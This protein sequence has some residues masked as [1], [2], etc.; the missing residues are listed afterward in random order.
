MRAIRKRPAG[1]ALAS[2]KPRKNHLSSES[3]F[4][5]VGLPYRQVGTPP[6]T[7]SVKS[8]MRFKKLPNYVGL[9]SAAAFQG[10]SRHAVSTDI[11]YYFSKLSVEIPG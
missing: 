9:L 4:V 8:W 11:S 7:W 6:L 2:A 5:L 10:T 1:G 3:F